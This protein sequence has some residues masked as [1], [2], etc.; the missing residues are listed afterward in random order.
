M[1]ADTISGKENR[2]T[3][4]VDMGKREV[5]VSLNG[6]KKI[7]LGVKLPSEGVLP[8]VGFFGSSPDPVTVAGYKG[9][10]G[11]SV[12]KPSTWVPMKSLAGRFA[13]LCPAAPGPLPEGALPERIG[14]WAIILR[15]SRE[16]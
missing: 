5:S 3:F 6:K 1:L 9:S 16:C 4:I 10:A 2:L 14:P 8:Y 13:M 11:G 12:V 15:S 7:D